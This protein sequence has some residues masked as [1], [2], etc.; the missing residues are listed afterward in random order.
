MSRH[1]SNPRRVSFLESFIEIKL[2]TGDI[3]E[4]CRFNFSYYDDTQ[5]HGASFADLSAAD[6]ASIL[7][8]L[9]CYSKSSLNYW[10]NERCGGVRG[11]RVLADYDSFPEKSDFTH[12]KFVPTD[13]RWGRF[14]MENLSRLIGFT[15]P[16]EVAGAP[17]AKDGTPFDVNTFYVVFID[18]NHRFYLTEKK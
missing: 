15:I 10:R 4:R 13:V 5:L 1:G 7:E 2:A 9:R 18:P 16:G 6:L 12:P 17:L 3:R 14:R 8:K 11:L